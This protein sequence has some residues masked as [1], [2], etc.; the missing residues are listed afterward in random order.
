[1]QQDVSAICDG[2]KRQ[3][4]VFNIELF[5]SIILVVAKLI[6]LIANILLLSVLLKNVLSSGKSPSTLSSEISLQFPI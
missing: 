4:N 2:E 6:V 1:M 5:R 3:F